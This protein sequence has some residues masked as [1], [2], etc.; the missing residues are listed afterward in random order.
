L[1]AQDENPDKVTTLFGFNAEDLGDEVK[2]VLQVYDRD[3]DSIEG[4][5]S[6]NA[7]V[8]KSLADL[9]SIYLE[10]KLSI[11]RTIVLVGCASHR[12][13]LAVNWFNSEDN[14]PDYARVITKI[15]DLM[16]ALKTNKNRYKLAAK[17]PL[18]PETEGD[19]RWDSTGEMIDKALR[20][21]QF[22]PSCG[23]DRN[24]VA[25]IPSEP[26]WGHIMEL[27]GHLLN[28]KIVSKWLQTGVSEQTGQRK[29]VNFYSCRKAFNKLIEMY[30]AEAG[31]KGIEHW[32]G[33]NAEIIHDKNFEKALERIH[34][35]E[36]FSDLSPAQKT[37]L[38]VFRVRAPSRRPQEVVASAERREQHFMSEVFDDVEAQIEHNEARGDAGSIRPT[39]HVIRV[40]NCCERLFSAT[41]RIMTDSRKHMDPST[42]ETLIMLRMNKDLWDVRDVQWIIDNPSHFDET[43][44]SED[45]A[46]TNQSDDSD[47]ENINT[48]PTISTT[49]ATSS[50][51]SSS[52]STRTGGV[53]LVSGLGW[54][55]PQVGGGGG[56]NVRPRV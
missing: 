42:L 25:L 33:S 8:N 16:V 48:A 4:L 43:A 19:T 28:F 52:S 11:R 36:K 7:K 45:E 21:R 15:H 40:N 18:C 34:A 9:I 35:G 29:E 30:P 23:F 20:L 37:S 53:T 14:N 1:P 31:Q 6:D 12:L 39:K 46:G 3:F 47:D 2:R 49:S 32:L 17:T 56:R 41:K 38:S 13:S 22:L 54:R 5:S 44:G 24:T 27:Q 51:S 10:D 55:P 50:S 26:D